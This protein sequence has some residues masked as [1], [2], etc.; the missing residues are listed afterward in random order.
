MREINSTN[1]KEIGSPPYWSTAHLDAQ[2][3]G[4][5]QTWSSKWDLGSV[6]I[7]H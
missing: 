1:Q 7:H 6:D 5:K 2:S 4:I 3:G